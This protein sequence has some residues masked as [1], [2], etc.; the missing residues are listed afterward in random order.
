MSAIEHN[1]P[2]GD[3]ALALVTIAASAGALGPL[4]DVVATLPGGFRAAVVIAQHLG[5][6][7]ILPQIL[8]GDTAL[9]VTFA[10]DG[11]LL[12]AGTVY[13]C[14]PGHHI[15][16]A[17]DARIMLSDRE[18]LDFL[19]PSADWLFASAAAT[20]GDRAIG[21]VLSGMRRDGAAG[22]VSIKRAGGQ[23]IV[24]DPHTTQWGEMPAAAAAAAAAASEG[25]PSLV[26]TPREIGP[27]LG[28]MVSAINLEA[29]R[30]EWEHPFVR[31]STK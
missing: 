28:R 27:E 26:L 1:Q 13:V 30:A 11:T 21:V 16:I 5:G 7:S 20:Y 10:S 6:W 9:P 14:P 8:A 12:H 29:G 18:R 2:N 31:Q 22:V 4:R 15:S 17:P 25:R 23:V 19:R 24:Q 3:A